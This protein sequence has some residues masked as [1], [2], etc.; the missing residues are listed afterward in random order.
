MREIEVPKLS[1]EYRYRRMLDIAYTAL[2]AGMKFVRE[3]YG[4][5]AAIELYKRVQPTMSARTGTKLL[6]E[7]KLE[8]TVEG[9]LKLAKLYSSEVWGFGA[10]EYVSAVLEA[11]G[12]G[13][14]QNKVCRIW[15]RRE[16]F[17]FAGMQ[18]HKTC[19]EEYRGLIRQL[20]PQLK[21]Q[22]TKALPLGDEVC[23]FVIEE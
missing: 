13:V 4:D 8:P 11:P 15:A 9:A 23:E 6:K 10:D 3:K 20:S 12:K 1:W 5:E 22:M 21:V 19:V 2:V 18:C 16:D 17:G 7:F 14:Y